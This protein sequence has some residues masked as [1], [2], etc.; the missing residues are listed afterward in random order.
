MPDS[1]ISELP[2]QNCDPA[3]LGG[4]GLVHGDRQPVVGFEEVAELDAVGKTM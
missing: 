1:E 2:V 3:G 4:D